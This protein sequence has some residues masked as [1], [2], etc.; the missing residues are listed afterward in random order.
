MNIMDNKGWCKFRLVMLLCTAVVL[1]GCAEAIVIGGMSGLVVAHDARSTKGLFQDQAIEKSVLRVLARDKKLDDRGDFTVVSFNGAVLLTGQVRNEALKKR[2]TKLVSA[3]EGVRRVHN[4]VLVAARPVANSW[5]RD[6][7]TT[8]RVKAHL[9]FNDID[10]TRVKVV[11]ER[12]NIY[13]MGMVSR[14]E[15][16]RVLSMVANVDGIGRVTKVFEYVD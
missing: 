12:G 9:F 15:S 2:A 6:S 5:T 14:A 4:E 11:S 7:Y 13:L 3:V 16:E 8:A 1:Q 10:A